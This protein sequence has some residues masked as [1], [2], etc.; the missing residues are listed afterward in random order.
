[1]DDFV[2]NA[3]SKSNKRLISAHFGSFWRV[4]ADFTGREKYKTPSRAHGCL[5]RAG[6]REGGEGM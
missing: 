3:S 5:R 2:T 4:A 6:E 1:M